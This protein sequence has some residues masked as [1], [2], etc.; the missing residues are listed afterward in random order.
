ML[1]RYPY[2][3]LKG[4]N[5]W[6]LLCVGPEERSFSE[7][8]LNDLRELANEAVLRIERRAGRDV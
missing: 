2:D 7:E 6:F 4:T 3:H 1:R 8:D 5:Y